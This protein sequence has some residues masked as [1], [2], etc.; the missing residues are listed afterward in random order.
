MKNFDNFSDRQS[1][2]S[3]FEKRSVAS[4]MLVNDF[5]G[6]KSKIITTLRQIDELRSGVVKQSVFENIL[7]CMDVELE[8]DDLDECRRKLGLTY[9]GASYIKYDVAVR[10]LFFDN[11]SEKW[12]I[13]RTNDDGD[14]L[15]VIAENVGRRA[16]RNGYK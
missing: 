2:F 13:R 6:K 9:Q 1:I 10:M 8:Q 3:Q 12:A 7:T 14:T 11:H 15:S 4:S 5:N 16:G